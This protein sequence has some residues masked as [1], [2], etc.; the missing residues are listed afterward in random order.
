MVAIKKGKKIDF[1]EKRG[2]MRSD[3]IGSKKGGL[4]F[5]RQG[6]GKFVGKKEKPH[7]NQ[8]GLAKSKGEKW[9][10]LLQI[11]LN[12]ERKTCAMGGGKKSLK[13]GGPTSAG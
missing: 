1:R 11:K 5:L 3:I 12:T 9:W 13:Q 8:K 4:R 6:K 2:R 10:E 7:L